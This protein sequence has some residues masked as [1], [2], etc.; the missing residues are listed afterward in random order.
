MS[1]RTGTIAEWESRNKIKA[2]SWQQAQGDCKEIEALNPYDRAA[3]PGSILK[4]ESDNFE[5]GDPKTAKQRQLYCLAI[6]AKRY[7]LFVK[8]APNGRS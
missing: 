8:G 6:S 5:N 3:V 7:S 1:V 2:L 4:I